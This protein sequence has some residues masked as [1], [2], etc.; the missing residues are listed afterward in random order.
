MDSRGHSGGIALLWR[1]KEEVSIRS[2]SNNHI[3]AMIKPKIGQEFRL[4]GIYGE[5][6]RSKRE[7]TWNLIRKLAENNSYPWCLIGDMNNVLH[8]QDKRGGRPYPQWLI[9]GFN[10][11]LEECDLIDMNLV[12]YQFTWERS[13]GSANCI[14]VR[15]DRALVTPTFLNLFKDARLVN[16]EVSTSDHCPI[17][18][19]TSSSQ[20]VKQNKAF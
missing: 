16:L 8:Q 2:Y 12:G 4:C 15:L 14:E 6:N 1:N 3:D 5:P 17:M 20:F 19:E 9:Q 10:E 18:L 7:E 11:V 13:F